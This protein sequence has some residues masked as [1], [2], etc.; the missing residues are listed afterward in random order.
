MNMEG[1]FVVLC[2]STDPQCSKKIRSYLFDEVEAIPVDMCGGKFHD[3][4]CQDTYYLEK[5]PIDL[6]DVIDTSPLYRT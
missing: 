1:R 3:C 6:K 4:S 5:V 2:K